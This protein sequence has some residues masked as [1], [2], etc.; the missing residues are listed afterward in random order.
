L[1]IKIF[2]QIDFVKTIFKTANIVQLSFTSESFC[3][4]MKIKIDPTYENS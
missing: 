2:T 4:Q 3:L 1:P